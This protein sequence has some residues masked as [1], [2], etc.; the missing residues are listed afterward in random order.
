MAPGVP[1]WVS[2]VVVAVHPGDVGATSVIQVATINCSTR[3]YRAFT[4][5]DQYTGVVG[6]GISTASRVRPAII[7]AV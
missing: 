3:I 4:L 5:Y 6:C 2:N 7:W 1:P